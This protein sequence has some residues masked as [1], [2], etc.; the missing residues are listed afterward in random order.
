MSLSRRARR[1]SESGGLKEAAT[2]IPSRSP[3]LHLPCATRRRQACRTQTQ[4]CLRAAATT[5]AEGSRALWPPPW[6][7]TSSAVPPP[8]SVHPCDI[9]PLSSRAQAAAT[10]LWSSPSTCGARA[11]AKRVAGA[12]ADPAAA[13]PPPAPV[14][15]RRARCSSSRRR[16]AARASSCCTW[17]ASS[18]SAPPPSRRCRAA[19]CCRS[20]SRWSSCL[21]YPR[22]WQASCRWYGDDSV[23]VHRPAPT[24]TESRKP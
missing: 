12:A 24:R 5:T 10:L 13:E 4:A 8:C 3:R 7:T 18:C 23:G 6:S 14:H 19:C 1:R 9:H 22:L 17:R 21:T 15:T 11:A 16:C 2:T 20:E